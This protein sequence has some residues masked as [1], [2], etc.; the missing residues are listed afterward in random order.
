MEAEFY[1]LLG[2]LE[3]EQKNKIENFLSIDKPVFAEEV[4]APWRDLYRALEFLELPDHISSPSPACLLLGWQAGPDRAEL[5]ELIAPFQKAKV[6]V[7]NMLLIFDG[8]DAVRV[9]SL[10]EADWD[11]GCALT[12][13]EGSFSSS[14]RVAQWMMRSL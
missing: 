4:G 7:T 10:E 2:A 1:V 5:Y 3:P 13:I 8:V 14:K 12:A 11:S 6:L 9:K